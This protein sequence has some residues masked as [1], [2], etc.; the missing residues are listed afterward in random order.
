MKKIKEKNRKDITT[1]NYKETPL[2]QRKEKN[3]LQ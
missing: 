1:T 3:K 2:N